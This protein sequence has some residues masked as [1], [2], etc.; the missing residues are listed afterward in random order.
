MPRPTNH[1]LEAQK[2]Q[3][4]Q[5]YDSNVEIPEILHVLQRDGVTVTQRTLERYLKRWKEEAGLQGVLRR[6]A[7]N[8][9]EVAAIQQLLPELVFDMFLKDQEILQEL[10]QRG[11]NIRSTWK[12]AE[13]RRAANIPRWKR[14]NDKDYNFWLVEKVQEAL[15]DGFV[16]RFGVVNLYTSLRLDGVIVPHQRLIQIMRDRDPAGVERRRRV[17]KGGSRRKYTVPG[18]NKVWSMD[19]HCKLEHFGFIVYGIMD[20]FSRYMIHCTVGPYHR[21][22]RAVA[23]IYAKE[24]QGRGFIPSILPPHALEKQNKLPLSSALY[25]ARLQPTRGSSLG[26]HS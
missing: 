14:L 5:L 16:E 1:A 13:L 20:A 24:C 11:F 15:D 19:A 2:E 4:L 22:Q 8:D 12:V 26:G 7:M 21:S 25:M 3:A 6:P 10:Q 17:V 9:G 18:P 23:R